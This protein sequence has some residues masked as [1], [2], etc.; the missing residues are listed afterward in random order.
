MIARALA[1]FLA[2]TLLAASTA[3]F[4]AAELRVA[5]A[6]NFLGTLQVL[7]EDY[8][9]QSGVRLLISA[10]S[11]GAL[12]AQIVNGAPFDVFLSADSARPAALVEAGLAAPG[13]RF[14]YAIGVPVL[15]SARPG[16]VDDAGAVLRGAGFRHLALADPRNAPY[17][18]AAQ[19][20]LEHLG[21]WQRLGDER[22]LVRAQ[23]IGQAYSQVASGAAPLGFV[24]LAQVLAED[25][26][27]AGSHW[28]PPSDWHAP[29][30]QQAV[31]L[32]SGDQARSAA[33]LA[34]LR[35][36]P[37]AAAIAAAGYRQD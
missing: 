9:A 4:A 22:R 12:Y 14:T 34:W 8:R 31:A 7:A 17:G 23:S 15:W 19:Q 26:S 27:I 28:I 10:G 35:S 30:V 37:A 1:R 25:G 6:A 32:R 33:F 36:P 29:I 13:S 11:S 3:S 24:A 5:V 21:L 18:A 20:V 16:L 2:L